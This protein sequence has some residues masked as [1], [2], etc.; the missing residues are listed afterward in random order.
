MPEYPGDTSTPVVM[1]ALDPDDVWDYA[2]EWDPTTDPWLASGET[3]AAV[4]V[5]IYDSTGA[6]TTKVKAGD[7]STEVS[8][9]AG[10]VTPPAPAISGDSTVTVWLYVDTA[11]AGEV[12]TISVTVRTSANRVKTKSFT[13]TIA[14]T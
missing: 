9:P 12:Y 1:P 3:L 4:A 10:N 2:E 6:A 8:T 13:V 14:E 11:V 7:G 5:A